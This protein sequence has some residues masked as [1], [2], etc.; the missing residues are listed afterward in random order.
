MDREPVSST[1]NGAAQNKRSK[2]SVLEDLREG[3]DLLKHLNEQLSIISEN[4]ADA[5]SGGSSTEEL[6][7][8]LKKKLEAVSAL[9]KVSKRLVRIREELENHTLSQDDREYFVALKESLKESMTHLLERHDEN[10]S[11]LSRNGISIRRPYH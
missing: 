3:Y 5:I 4:I 2:A 9:E 6:N 1:D 10:R 8:F 7:G 11:T